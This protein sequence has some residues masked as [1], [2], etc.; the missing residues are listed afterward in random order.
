[1][2]THIPHHLYNMMCVV[3]YD[4]ERTVFNLQMKLDCRVFLEEVDTS[5]RGVIKV[6]EINRFDTLKLIL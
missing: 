1:M 3:C 4:R 5:Q 6:S 2:T